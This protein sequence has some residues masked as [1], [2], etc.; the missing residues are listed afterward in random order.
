MFPGNFN[1]LVSFIQIELSEN[2][3][4][5]WLL[6]EFSKNILASSNEVYII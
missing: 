5:S 6:E 1:L 4:N 3:G 2:L